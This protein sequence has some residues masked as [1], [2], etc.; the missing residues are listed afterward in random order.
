M[1]IKIAQNIKGIIL[2]LII[3]I[4]VGYAGAQTF[5]G[6][7]CAPTDPIGCNTPAPINVGSLPQVKTGTLSLVDLVA[8]NFKLTNPDGTATNIPAGSFMVSNGSNTGVAK[9]GSCKIKQGIYDSN[10]GNGIADARV[11]FSSPFPSGTNPVVIVTPIE[12][13]GIYNFSIFYVKNVDNTG[14][15]VNVQHADAIYY[16]AMDGCGN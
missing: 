16:I 12:T 5:E 7:E 8:A 3:V 10:S 4:G 1:K 2:G 6:P 14:F 15:N 11:T 13:P 9:W